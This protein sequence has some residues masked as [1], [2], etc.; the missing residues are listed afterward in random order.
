[1]EAARGPQTFSE[2]AS[3]V[4]RFHEPSRSKSTF[5]HANACRAWI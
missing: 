3:S 2:S 1:M 4:R 5:E